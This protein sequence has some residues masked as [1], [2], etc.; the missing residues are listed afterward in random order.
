MAPFLGELKRRKVLQVGVAYAAAGWVLIEV[1]TAV[2]EPLSLPNWADT[3]V[4]VLVALGL[5]LALILGWAFDV[6]VVKDTDSEKSL[7]KATEGA[8]VAVQPADGKTAVLPNSI[9]VLPFENLSPE[10]EHAYF[11]AGIHDTILNELAKVRDMNVIARTSVLHY[12]D[13]KMP[14]K[15][16]ARELNVQTIMEGSVQY[17]DGKVRVTA[18]LIDPTTSAHI[19]SESFDRDFSEIFSIQAEIATQIA[20]SMQAQLLPN[21]RASI[22]RPLTD[23][24][25]AYAKYL[26]A[27]AII[28]E[29]ENAFGVAASPRTRAAIQIYL[30]GA[31]ESDPNFAAAHAWKAWLYVWSRT[32]DPLSP[33]HWLAQLEEL[34]D[35]ARD[36]AERA[37]DTDPTLGFAYA[38]RGMF[39]MHQWN[40]REARRDF[41][42]ALRLSPNDPQVLVSASLLEFLAD[43][44]AELIR[45]LERAAILDPNAIIIRNYLANGFHPLGEYEQAVESQKLCNSMDPSQP[46]PYV[47]RARAESALGDQQ[48]AL[49]SL[50]MAEQLLPNDPAVAFLSEFIYGYGRLG[51]HE[52]AQRL[53]V[54][55]KAE[56]ESIYVDP[57]VWVW[58][59][60]G[61]G[62]TEQAL[63]NLK[64]GAN[65]RRLL[66][67]AWLSAFQRQN[68]WVDP[69]LERP[70]FAEVLQRLRFEDNE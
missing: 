42:A 22:E 6:K 8:K 33:E 2:E 9:A 43:R 16:I 17:A 3:L 60:L 52:D 40:S 62:D 48:A 41:E 7:A 38:A 37:L 34:D 70:E 58:A 49:Q 13:L 61:I 51:Q 55:L 5:P 25:K 31:L 21:E 23:S 28:R 63:V 66:Q 11:A 14:I 12:A 15:E 10:Q 36:H 19:W 56:A 67:Q 47:F 20:R 57:S 27:I 50:R 45:L 30:D 32:F 59:Y 1:I 46:V 65:D 18:Q 39:Q 69:V 29:G 54:R 53:F 24:P 44:P 4:I 26:Q 68:T 64:K 35:L